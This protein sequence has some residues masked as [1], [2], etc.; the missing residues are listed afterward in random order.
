MMLYNF[1]FAQSYLTLS[2]NLKG[3]NICLNKYYLVSE[4]Y[5]I[6]ETRHNQV[7]THFKYNLNY[8]R[9]NLSLRAHVQIEVE[10]GKPY[11]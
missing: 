2:N 6:S 5:G 8:K 9:R 3:W 11:G 4:I 10:Q 1:N 7:Q